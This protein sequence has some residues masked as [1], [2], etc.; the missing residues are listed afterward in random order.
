MQVYRPLTFTQPNGESLEPYIIHANGIPTY[1][2]PRSQGYNFATRILFH[3]KED[4]DYY[5]NECPTHE[6]LKSIWKPKLAGPP[7][8]LYA[9]AAA[10]MTGQGPVAN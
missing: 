1:D 5:D 8:V 4:M 9:D 3:S 10:F 2:D 7:L 6:E